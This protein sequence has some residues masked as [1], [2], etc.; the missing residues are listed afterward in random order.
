VSEVQA[1]DAIT[2]IYI[3]APFILPFDD[4]GPGFSQT[5]P[6]A[7]SFNFGSA[8][9]A[10]LSVRDAIESYRRAQY[11]VAGSTVAA[12]NDDSVFDDDDEE[13]LHGLQDEDIEEEEEEGEIAGIDVP[14]RAREDSFTGLP[15]DE[16]Y[17]SIQSSPA[18]PSVLRPFGRRPQPNRSQTITQGSYGIARTPTSYLE[19][20]TGPSSIVRR[21]S[22]DTP[23]LKKTVSFSTL[24]QPQRP[25]DVSSPTKGAEP[26]AEGSVSGPLRRRLSSAS[27][28]SGAKHHRGGQSTYGQTLFNSIAILLGIGMLSEPLAFAYSGWTIGTF[29]IIAYGYVAC[30]TAK[31]LARVI[32]SDSRLRSYSD[33]GKKAF[34]PKVMPFIS[35]MFCLEL[36]AVR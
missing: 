2:A 27:A 20:P 5:M 15:W 31:I 1:P 21:P 19:V 23:L 13:A 11:L 33:I 30:Y 17:D 28:M 32:L 8:S 4:L 10:R 3:N 22:E 34:G 6:S 29:L 7:S 25:T 26:I 35:V 16:D 18:A 9:S 24:A 14:S 36:F 12:T